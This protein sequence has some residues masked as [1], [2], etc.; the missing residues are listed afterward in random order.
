MHDTTNDEKTKNDVNEELN[1]YFKENPID[2]LTR[3]YVRINDLCKEDE[4]VLEDAEVLEDIDDEKIKIDDYL[5]KGNF[6][7]I[8]ELDQFKI[9]IYEEIKEI[10]E[11]ANDATDAAESLVKKAKEYGAYDNVTVICIRFIQEV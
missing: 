6:L 9:K 4:A 7:K 2:E 8:E 3:M 11:N 10:T 1:E 5:I